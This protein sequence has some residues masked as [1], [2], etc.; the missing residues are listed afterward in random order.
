MNRLLGRLGEYYYSKLIS[1]PTPIVTALAVLLLLAYTSKICII[2]ALTTTLAAALC[3]VA[4]LEPRRLLALAA[5]QLSLALASTLDARLV[6]SHICFN[7]L[8]T[9][10]VY[11]TTPRPIL[12]LAYA[13]LQVLVTSRIYGV[14]KLPSLLLG[15]LLALSPLAVLPSRERL[16]TLKLIRALLRVVLEDDEEAL[17][18]L[19]LESSETRTLTHYIVAYKL[20]NGSCIAVVVPAAHFGP[21]RSAGSSKLPYMILEEMEKKGIKAIVLHAAVTHEE[22]LV[23]SNDSIKLAKLLALEAEKLCRETSR[24]CKPLALPPINVAGYHVE[25]LPAPIPIL[26]VSRPGKGIDDFKLPTPVPAAVVDLHNMEEYEPPT[27]TELEQLADKI[28]EA[29]KHA[30]TVKKLELGYVVHHL[31][32]HTAKKLGTCMP[33]LQALHVETEETHATLVVAPSNNASPRLLEKLTSMPG[34]IQLATLDDHYCTATTKKTPNWVLRDNSYTLKAVANLVDKASKSARKVIACTASITTTTAR[35]W[36]R[37]F[38]EKLE[39]IAAASTTAPLA[40]LLAVV[41][42]LILPPLLGL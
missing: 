3:S 13:L 42:S 5:V 37:E 17:R 16:Y 34:N 7:G 19:A 25:A 38:Y 12:A 27:R 35:V 28:L 26:L 21:M 39:R 23:S 15:Y 33:W 29:L 22:N 8:L 14:E 30:K 18:S 1:T 24:D 20:D 6:S 10:A 31:D 36:G 41:A 11:A 40:A 32:K 2:Y 4:L 9:I